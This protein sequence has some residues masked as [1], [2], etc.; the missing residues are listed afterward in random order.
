MKTLDPCEPCFWQHPSWR[1]SLCLAI[2]PKSRSPS[3]SSIPSGWFMPA[4][5][6]TAS[7]PKQSTTAA[8]TRS[9][10]STC[11]EKTVLLVFA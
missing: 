10:G 8:E 1:M 2:P 4:L 6:S 7:M 5:F 3:K 9:H 11:L